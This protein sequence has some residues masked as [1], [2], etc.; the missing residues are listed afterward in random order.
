MDYQEKLKDP[1]WHKRRRQILV[2]DFFICQK[3][4]HKAV[5]N[6]VHHVVYL[7]EHEP[8][9][10]DDEYLITLCGRCHT[11]EHIDSKHISDII[12]NMKLSGMFCSEIK[13]KMNVKFN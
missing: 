7:F 9:E 2:R 8:W 11:L 10:Y 6:H 3:C 13:A 4:G 12:K 5:N 1:R